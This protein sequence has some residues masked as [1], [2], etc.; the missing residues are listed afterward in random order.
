MFVAGVGLKQTCP[1]LNF[2]LVLKERNQPVVVDCDKVFLI[3]KSNDPY[4]LLG[5]DD[6]DSFA[7]ESYKI[8][9][10]GSSGRFELHT[11]QEIQCN[12]CLILCEAPP[13]RCDSF[14]KPTVIVPTYERL[15]PFHYVID[16]LPSGSRL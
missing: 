14:I 6:F 7:R 2:S 16:L 5:F 9:R 12:L 1:L 11:V 10:K 4:S 13:D 15:Q 8:E 3:H